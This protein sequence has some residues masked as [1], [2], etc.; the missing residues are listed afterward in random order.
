MNLRMTR[1]IIFHKKISMNSAFM[2]QL[3]DVS[4]DLD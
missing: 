2:Q 3:A 1:F 4:Y